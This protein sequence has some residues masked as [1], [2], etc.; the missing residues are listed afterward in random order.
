M[1]RVTAIEAL[2]AWLREASGTWPVATL[3]AWSFAV[4]DG[5]PLLIHL[6]AHLDGLPDAAGLDDLACA[7]TEVAAR[8][9]FGVGFRFEVELVRPGAPPVA[10]PDG[11]L[12]IRDRAEGAAQE[13]P[14]RIDWDRQS[15]YLPPGHPK[16]RP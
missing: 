14:Y 16:R 10:L 13:P 2:P 8:T 11:M 9:S 5:P 15:R 1:Q 7:E 4:S 12:V 3:F 6:K